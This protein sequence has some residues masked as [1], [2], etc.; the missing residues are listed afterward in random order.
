MADYQCGSCSYGSD[1]LDELQQHSRETGHVGTRKNDAEQA[2]G[3]F[4]KARAAA[5]AGAK[6][7]A[8]AAVVGFSAWKYKALQSMAAG[9]VVQLAESA[10]ENAA[11]KS[12]N[13]HLKSENDYLRSAT[14]AGKTLNGFRG[15]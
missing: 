11:L 6:V 10:T 9:L 13:E 14:G 12:E 1:D 7:L 15:L 3:K 5:K 2:E 8:V 4:G